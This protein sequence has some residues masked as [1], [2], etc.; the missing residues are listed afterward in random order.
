MATYTI[1]NESKR[2]GRTHKGLTTEQAVEKIQ[3]LAADMEG[4]GWTI[5]QPFSHYTH[6]HQYGIRLAIMEGDK[7]T[8][9]VHL[10]VTL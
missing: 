5:T 10:F 9:R 4:S 6:K 1:Y 3:S 7:L 2:E 8:N